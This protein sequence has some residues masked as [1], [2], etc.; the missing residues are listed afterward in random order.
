[1]LFSI[2]FIWLEFLQDICCITFTENNIKKKIV[3]FKSFSFTFLWVC[4]CLNKQKGPLLY[5]S[6]FYSHFNHHQC[7][8]I[9]VMSILLY[10]HLYNKE[11]ISKELKWNSQHIMTIHVFIHPCH[12]K[13]ITITIPNLSDVFGI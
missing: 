4:N 13:C 1:M 10:I 3:T 8:T 5:I 2:L 9:Q 11:Q 6:W 12:L 7:W